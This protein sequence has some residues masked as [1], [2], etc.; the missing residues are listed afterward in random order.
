LDWTNTTNKPDPTITLGGDLTGSVT[1]TDLASGTLTATIAENSVTLGTDT[2]GNYVSDVT[3]G[4]GITVTHTPGEGSSAAIALTNS[5][6]TVNGTSISL[7]GSGTVTADAGTLTGATLSSGVTASSLTSVGILNNLNVT[8]TS[9][10]ATP[11][12]VKGAFGQGFPLI[13]VTNS[14]DQSVAYV[15][16]TGRIY[17][18]HSLQVQAVSG[19]AAAALI[20]TL[21]AVPG[22]IV[23]AD[24]TQTANL[25]EWYSAG[26]GGTVATV[27]PAGLITTASDIA[28][29][30]GDI[31]T[32]STGTATVFNTNATTLNL[33][34]AATTVSIG[35]GSG[36]TTVNNALVV[37]GD[38]TVNGTT[39][40]M[41]TTTISVD[42]KNIELGAVASPTDVTAD[43]G[44]ITLKGAT[45]KTFNWVDATD[46]WT[47][48]EH[49]N[50]ASGKVYRIDGTSVLSSTTLGSGV[51]S[52]SLTSVGTI[53]TGTWNGS[54]VAGQYGGTGVANTDKTITIGGNF[55]TTGAHALDFTLAGATSVTMPTSGTVISTSNPNLIADD[56]QLILA[57]QIFG[58]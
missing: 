27:S 21:G 44:G 46:A 36:T 1:L 33:G 48:S 54:V 19:V 53:T 47:S 41:N 4:T 49:M 31:T 51:T 2:T 7:G 43:G 16:A 38:L 3:S 24:N 56:D 40:T 20:E 14:A 8:T 13:N 32:T 22:L 39:T 30:G 6:L 28:V 52:S 45:D 35:A 11:L 42:D 29:N 37:T 25:Q 15:D 12:T 17:T 26:A 23:F 5:S 58:R 9:G 10:A 34:G 18:G 55:S 57:S 50:L